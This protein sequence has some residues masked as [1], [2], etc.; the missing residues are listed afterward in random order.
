MHKI[1]HE[2]GKLLLKL[3][4]QMVHW[5]KSDMKNEAHKWSFQ[6]LMH[7]L[8]FQSKGSLHS[9]QIYCNVCRSVERVE[10]QLLV[11]EQLQPQGS[12]LTKSSF[13]KKTELS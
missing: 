6:L 5:S 13:Q 10:D 8:K 12:C 9:S 2:I 1:K 3:A 11:D 4:T 7:L